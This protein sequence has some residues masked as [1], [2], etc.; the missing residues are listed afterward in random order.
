MTKPLTL[1]IEDDPQLGQIFS[2]TLQHDFSVEVLRD[3]PAALKRLEQVRPALIVLDLHLPDV[4]G[5]TILIK[6]R[7]DE[8]LAKVPVILATAD[9]R[10]ADELS[11]QADIV[12]LKPIS[13]IQLREIAARLHSSL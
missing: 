8:R 11:D 5:K 7:A 3:G 13:P 12:L 6:I 4:S 10:Q 2:I 1:I 9:A